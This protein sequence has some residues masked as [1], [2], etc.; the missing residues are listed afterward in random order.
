[1]KGK[2]DLIEKR[3]SS[4]YK[5]LERCDLCPRNCRI[6]RLKNQ[7]G[8]CKA[9]KDIVIYTA[10]LHQGEEPGISEGKGSGTI[11]FS[12]CNLKCVFCQNHKFSHS[13]EG[14]LI[15]EDTLAKIIINLQKKGASNINLVTPTHYLAQILK[16]LATALEYGLNLP[17]VYN[18][19]GYEKKEVIEQLEGIVDIYLT[20][21]KYTSS[22]AANSYSNASKYPIFAS[23]S[24][25][26][27]ARQVEL[28]WSQNQLKM[29]LIIRH[30]A[31]PGHVEESKQALSWIKQNIPQALISVMFQYQP[32]FKANRYPEIN[33]KITLPEYQEIKEFVEKLGLDG[34]LQ[35]FNP[36][37][38]L[39]GV[40]FSSNLEI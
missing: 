18:T 17:I 40:N 39:A 22:E 35:D 21:L 30:L 8:Y 23:E 34:W 33:R 28:L 13:L 25:K 15:D 3:L 20:D 27:M 26:E 6:N 24:L 11:F 10:F 38:E 1:M 16:A 12:G 31:L 7:T 37:K 32:Y 19:S 2:I 14:K 4:L 9:G 36:C 29:G 5:R